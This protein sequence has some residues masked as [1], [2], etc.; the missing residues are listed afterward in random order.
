[1]HL[2][3]TDIHLKVAVLS[4]VQQVKTSKATESCPEW[5]ARTRS[6]CHLRAKKVTPQANTKRYRRDQIRQQKYSPE[7][8][9]ALVD[10]PPTWQT[11]PFSHVCSTKQHI[12]GSL[13]SKGIL[14]SL[15]NTIDRW[16]KHTATAVSR[17]PSEHTGFIHA[18][19]RTHTHT[20]IECWG[21]TRLTYQTTS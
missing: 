5:C 18:R 13:F 8:C 19:A 14:S 16:G 20:H 6:P 15:K 9:I 11:C 1:M 7:T 10:R 3:A 4:N 12:K 21:H 17:I 2:N